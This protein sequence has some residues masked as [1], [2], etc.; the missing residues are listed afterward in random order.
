MLII[1]N[2]KLDKK[3]IELC[4]LICLLSA[5]EIFYTIQNDFVAFSLEHV[6]VLIAYVLISILTI[7]W[8]KHF[9]SQKAK[10][11]AGMIL[12]LIPLL[13]VILRIYFKYHFGEFTY[14]KDL[15]LFI[16]RLVSFVLPI[17]IWTKN[18]AL[19]GVLYFWVIAGTTNALITPDIEYG[20][21][22]MESIFYWMIH[23]GLVMSI[24]Y[25]VFVYGWK[26]KRRDIWRAF[27][28]ANFYLV[29]IHGLNSLMGSNYS[30]T[31]HKPINGSI[32]DFFGPWPWYLPTGQLLALF[33]FLLF[34]LP[35]YFVEKSSK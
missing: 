19:F 32:L 31:M 8:A 5:M 30:Y 35:F 34:Y 25:C 1:T 33:L 10:D 28:W 2:P 14:V 7:Y 22:H 4:D 3:R 17:L 29:F 27:M 6:T 21:P 15:P 23:A 13:A 26:P 11:R 20:L 16:C 24:L 18:R 9:L 12:A